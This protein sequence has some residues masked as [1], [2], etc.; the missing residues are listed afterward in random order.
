EEKSGLYRKPSCGEMS[1]MHAC[2]MNFAPVCGTD[3]NTYP[4]EC[5]LC[6]QRQ[7]TKTDILITK[8]DRC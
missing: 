7:N 4:N 2:P 8:D 1:A 3:G 5:S 6:F